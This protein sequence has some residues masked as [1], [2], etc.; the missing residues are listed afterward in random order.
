M[1]G[2]VAMTIADSLSAYASA[3]A[4]GKTLHALPTDTV[5]HT[6]ADLDDFEREMLDDDWG[7]LGYQLGSTG[8]RMSIGYGSVRMFRSF[9]DSNRVH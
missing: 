6:E 3:E 2:D 8:Q 4:M 9:V 7:V 1:K 5:L